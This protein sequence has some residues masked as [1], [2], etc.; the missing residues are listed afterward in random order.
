MF[1]KGAAYKVTWICKLQKSMLF[2]K[3]HSGDVKLYSVPSIMISTWKHFK[4]LDFKIM[5]LE[6]S[7]YMGFWNISWTHFPPGNYSY[8]KKNAFVCRTRTFC[9]TV[10][11]GMSN[12]TFTFPCENCM[13]VLWLALITILLNSTM[14]GH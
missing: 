12:I 13:S 4:A 3:F 1:L 5:F 8:G 9:T 2:W 7:E 11:L 6:Y 14:Y 10:M